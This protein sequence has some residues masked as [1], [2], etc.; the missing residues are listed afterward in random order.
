MQPTSNEH[1]MRYYGW[2]VTA[3]LAITELT[4]WGILFYSFSVMVTPMSTDLGWSAGTVTGA[5]AVAFLISGVSAIVVGRWLD[6]SGS[7]VVMSIGSCLG[8]VLL[9][10]WAQ[11]TTPLE[12]YLVWA[13]LGVATAMVF[14]EPAFAAVATWFSDLRRLSVTIVTLGGA[15]A[16]VVFVPVSTW[17]VLQMGW[18]SAVVALAIILALVTIPLHVGV[19]RR[20]SQ[21]SV[22]SGVAAPKP[23]RA[24]QIVRRPG[25]W[26]VSAAFAFSAF[27]WVAMATYLI[28]YLI[29]HH[30]E[31][32][33]AAAIVGVMG[34]SQIVGRV[35]LLVVHRW[36]GDRWTVPFFFLLQ[37]VALGFLLLSSAPWQV[38]V[39]AFLFGVGFGG[40]YPARA[41]V[42][43]D[44]FGTQAYGQINGVIAFLMTLTAA[45]G[46]LAMS[47]VNA[48]FS[49]YDGAM[50]LVL[51]GSIIAAA[52]IVSLEVFSP[53]THHPVS[54]EIELQQ[55]Q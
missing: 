16:S 8:A 35:L 34:A 45:L 27:T 24:L 37:I 44:R 18:R 31:A 43:A 15:L 33:F 21:G 12:L 22:D 13:G 51:L 19:V 14:Y 28:P 42:V 52:A 4:S 30:Y 40:S 2:A 38:G 36:F 54:G 48:R 26:R 46:V 17:L 41:T 53:L 9:L 47:A 10:L 7:R 55:A 50:L 32:G 3:S 20:R 6:R 11:V 1:S 5:F 49:T 39:F 29:S 25:F 23:L